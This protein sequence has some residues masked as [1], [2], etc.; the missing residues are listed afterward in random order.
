M[1]APMIRNPRISLYLIMTMAMLVLCTSSHATTLF[2]TV[3][4]TGSDAKVVSITQSEGGIDIASYHFR[5][6]NSGFSAIADK[7]ISVDCSV[8]TILIRGEISTPSGYTKTLYTCGETISDIDYT[9]ND[10]WIYSQYLG[11]INISYYPNVYSTTDG[12][13]YIHQQENDVFCINNY[14]NDT[15]TIRDLRQE[16]NTRNI[17]Q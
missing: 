5:R 12:W 3:S 6:F 16:W 8:P 1:N 15:W 14:G 10:G 2:T 17:I 7:T 11:W 4:D 13:Q 9:M